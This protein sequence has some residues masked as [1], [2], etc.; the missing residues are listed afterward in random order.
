MATEST[1]T[2]IRSLGAFLIDTY[3]S[4]IERSEKRKMHASSSENKKKKIRNTKKDA[5]YTK[6]IF[7]RLNRKPNL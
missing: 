2:P 7:K 3:L 5:S 6:R 4:Y 1:C